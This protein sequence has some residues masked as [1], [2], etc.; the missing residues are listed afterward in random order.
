MARCKVLGC[1]CFCAVQTSKVP[2]VPLCMRVSCEGSGVVR[3]GAEVRFREGSAEGSAKIP[4]GFSLWPAFIDRAG[5]FAGRN[6]EPHAAVELILQR[7]VG[8]SR[9]VSSQSLTSE[10]CRTPARPNVKPWSPFQQTAG[11]TVEISNLSRPLK[12]KY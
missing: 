5:T 2:E 12:L 9:N 11:K 1:E 3:G 6:R 4:R 8:A 10:M 7:G